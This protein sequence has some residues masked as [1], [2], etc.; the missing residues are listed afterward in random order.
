MIWIHSTKWRITARHIVTLLTLTP[1]FFL[2][3]I[4]YSMPPQA[5]ARL[6]DANIHVA[7][8]RQDLQFLAT[9]LPRRHINAFHQITPAQFQAP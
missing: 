8:W 1:L 5:S 3:L 6:G 2:L 7:Q 9:E 4:G